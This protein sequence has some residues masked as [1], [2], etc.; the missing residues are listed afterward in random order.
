MRFFSIHRLHVEILSADLYSVVTSLMRFA[1]DVIFG[2]ATLQ[3]A[4]L[5]I[6]KSVRPSVRLSVCLSHS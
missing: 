4:A 3:S 1:V 2:R 5:A 6:A